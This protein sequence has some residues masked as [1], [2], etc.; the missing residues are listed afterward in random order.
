MRLASSWGK[1]TRSMTKPISAATAVNQL[2]VSKL[3]PIKIK[4]PTVYSGWRIQR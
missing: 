2:A 4:V 1:R 3:K